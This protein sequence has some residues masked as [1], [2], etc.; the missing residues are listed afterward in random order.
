MKKINYL[1]VFSII[2]VVLFTA[3]QKDPDSLNG[4]TPDEPF[5]CPDGYH[6]CG[7]DSTDCCLDTTSHNF[8]WEVDTLGGYMYVVK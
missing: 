2:L 6:I 8:V 1:T 7:S 3:C 5:E 4:D